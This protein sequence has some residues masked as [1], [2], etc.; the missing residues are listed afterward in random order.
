[1]FLM[2]CPSCCG[3]NLPIFQ[4]LYVGIPREPRQKR[5]G[6]KESPPQLKGRVGSDR[7]L[8]G[9]I[10]AAEQAQPGS[11]EDVESPD[12]GAAWMLGCSS[13]Q[14]LSAPV[15]CSGTQSRKPRS[16]LDR[17]RAPS[18]PQGQPGAGGGTVLSSGRKEVGEHASSYAFSWRKL[19]ESWCTSWPDSAGLAQL[20]SRSRARVRPSAS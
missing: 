14:F 20:A 13:G 15:G 10:M 2:A 8:P 1:M 19:G 3:G 4:L 5:H 9:G 7:F 6:G 17:S 18:C 12:P 11:E 16:P